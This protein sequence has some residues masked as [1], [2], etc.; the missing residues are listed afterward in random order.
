MESNRF[1]YWKGYLRIRIKS[2]YPERFF[3]ICASRNIRIW[4]ICSSEGEYEGSIRIS[5]FKKLL[6]VVRKTKTRLWI[7][8][9]CGFPFFLQNCWK[10]K[11]YVLGFFFF[12]LILYFASCHIWEIHIEGNLIYSNDILMDYLSENG[13]FSGM[14]K[15]Y[16]SCPE[17]ERLLRNQYEDITWVSASI[18]GSRLMIRIQENSDIVIYYEGNPAAADLIADHDAVISSIITRSGTPLV[19]KGDAVKKGDILVS[20]E[21]IIYDDFGAEVRREQVRADADILGEVTYSYQDKQAYQY[22][23]KEYTGNEQKGYAVTFGRMRF[24]LWAF[25]VPY[26]LF[27]R[28]SERSNL[29]FGTNFYLPISL[30]KWYYKE[31][32][33]CQGEYSKEQAAQL[34]LER[35]NQNF[36]NFIEKGLQIIK[37]DVKIS[38]EQ[39]EAVAS[40]L[41]VVQQK[42]GERTKRSNAEYSFEEGTEEAFHKIE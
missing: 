22:E 42:I 24:F 26:H 23:Y 12:F 14:N 7:R 1:A 15:N 27:D 33:V 2:G 37:N 32:A 40:G 28:I 31:Y 5:D 6:P 19:K 4:E 20:S 35:K 11:G 3:N 36:Q 25:P 13:I 41:V 16:V 10:R 17:I 8:N 18:A 38:I 21:V 39:N 9:R 30:E 29:K 34:L